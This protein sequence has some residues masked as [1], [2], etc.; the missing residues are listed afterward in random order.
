V[1]DG[2]PTRTQAKELLSVDM[3]GSVM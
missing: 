3:S 2:I 1:A